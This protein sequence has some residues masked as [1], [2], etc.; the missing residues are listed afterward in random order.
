MNS[1]QDL[2]NRLAISK[3]IMDKHTSIS[4]NQ[5]TSIDPG[6]PTVES[7]QPVAGNYNIPSELINEG[8]A[9][10]REY[11]NEVPT[12]DKIRNSRL[13]DEIKKLMIEHPIDKP[14]SM[15]GP[16]LSND[17]VEKAARLMGTNKGQPQLT[18]NIQLNNSTTKQNVSVDEIKTTIRDVVRDTVRDVIKEELRESGLLVES[19]KEANDTIQFKVGEHMFLGKILKIKKLSPK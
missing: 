3:K 2:L 16:T 1:E 17:L 14:N 8:V 19:T 4:R 6:S 13:P 15:S 10:P 12:E 7:F 5:N 18:E 11:N 9:T